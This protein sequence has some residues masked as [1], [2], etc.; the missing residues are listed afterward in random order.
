MRVVRMDECAIKHLAARPRS[1]S[2]RRHRCGSL[3]RSRVHLRAAPRCACGAPRGTAY[4]PR[5]RARTRRCGG[6]EGGS[7]CAHGGHRRAARP[8]RSP[9]SRLSG[10]PH[11]WGLRPWGPGGPGSTTH[12]AP[13]VV[14]LHRV[15]R[16]TQASAS[17]AGCE[18][19]GARH[20]IL[21]GP[22]RA[23][24]PAPSPTTEAGPAHGAPSP[25]RH[26]PPA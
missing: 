22:G 24:R 5:P 20:L 6:G 3:R 11:Y 9:R 7:Q 16:V 1:D 19:R 14:V 13:G 12:P 15:S 2:Q 25:R 18:A 10:A 17:P 4:R 8:G 23:P 26:A 21:S